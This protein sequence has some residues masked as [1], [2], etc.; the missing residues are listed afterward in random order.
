MDRPAIKR[1]LS[2]AALLLLTG[3]A[4]EELE[5]RT[6]RWT[7]PDRL[8]E[9]LSSEPAECLPPPADQ[10]AAL[11]IA[12]GRAA[13]RSPLLLGGQAARIGL[14]CDSCHRS[15]RGNTAFV[16]PGISG[17]PGTADVTTSVLS[18]HRGD[19]VFNPKPIPDL[20]GPKA[21]LKMDQTEAL[22]RLE[23][24]IRGQIMKE[25]NGPEPTPATLDG[26]ASYVRALSPQYC[27][28]PEPISLK[29]D[30][31]RADAALE[32]A[33]SLIRS[34]DPATAQVLVGA[35]RSTLG[36]V[37]ERYQPRSLRSRAAGLRRAAVSLGVI[38]RR[39]LANPQLAAR[40]LTAWLQA[41]ESWRAG[42]RRAEAQS[43]YNPALLQ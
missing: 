30:L 32:T 31:A 13:F 21:G 3:A 11:R 37:D 4:A 15:G 5:L 12:I 43:L 7:S 34:G 28:A 6:A 2:A 20:S 29:R 22:H 38:E 42:L 35:A 18:S 24:F 40:S 39:L 17:D 8:V 41:R 9:V 36:L 14:S 19:G 10:S 23:P 26:L 33:I 16:F 25:F 27:A 1:H